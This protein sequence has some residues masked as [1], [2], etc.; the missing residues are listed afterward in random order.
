MS[1]DAIATG[2]APA[3]IG[4]YSQAIRA[5]G[6][7]FV[8]GQIPLDPATGDLVGGGIGPQTERVVENLRAVLD[9]AGCDFGDVV[10]TTIFLTDLATFGTV[11]GI[12][13]RAFAPPFPARATV[14]VAALPR[15]SLVEIEAIAVVRAQT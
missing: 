12:Y 15:G 7:L 6:M 2:G 9:A 1:K 8:S 11:N 4:P 3:A 13:A 5:G 10:K 14:Q